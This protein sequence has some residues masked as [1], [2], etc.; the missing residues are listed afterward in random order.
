MVYWNQ[1]QVRKCLE[2][3]PKKVKYF[4][5]NDFYLSCSDIHGGVERSLRREGVIISRT[6]SGGVWK[7][8]NKAPITLKIWNI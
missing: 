3:R 8:A 2:F 7:I 6:C 5:V 1:N 4:S